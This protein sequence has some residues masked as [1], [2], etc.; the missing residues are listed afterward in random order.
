LAVT[1]RNFIKN[2][3]VQAAV[4]N[5]FD[6]KYSDPDTSGIA[7]KVPGDFPREGISGFLTVT[8]KF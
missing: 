8:Y 5:L 6:K 4:H 3:E 7:N 1:F 2:L